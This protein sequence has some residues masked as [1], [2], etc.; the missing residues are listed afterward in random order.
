MVR[1]FLSRVLA[2]AA[3]ALPSVAHAEWIEA[4]TKHFTIYSDDSAANVSKF[5]LSSE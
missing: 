3:L 5:A 2:I 4:T 1:K